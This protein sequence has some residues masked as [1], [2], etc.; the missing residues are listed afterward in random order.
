MKSIKL[1]SLLFIITSLQGCAGLFIAGAAT[2]AMVIT[3]QRST[4]LILKEKDLEFKITGIT[5][6]EPYRFNTRISANVYNGRT[7]LIGQA[8][9]ENL[10][11]KLAQQVQAMDGVKVLYNKIE[12]R[13]P[14]T[15]TEV[16]ND[17]WITTKVKSSLL[18][19][20]ELNSINIKVITENGYVYLIGFVTPEQSDIATEVARNIKGVK[21]VVRAFDYSE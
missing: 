14:L 12:V 19:E 21:G 7:L 16:N 13:E 1:I 3:D 20:S 15:F 6:K 17:I 8:K 2:T 4:K 18:T 5:N 11:Q 9:T 10:K